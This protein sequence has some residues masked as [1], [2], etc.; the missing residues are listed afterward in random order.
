MNAT[1]QYHI[2][3]GSDDIINEKPT[4]ALLSGDPER[5]RH[6]AQDMPGVIYKKCLSENRGLN[7]YLAQTESGINF[8]SATTGM[9]GP[10]TSIVM[11]E[12]YQL[13][14]H[15][16]IRIGTSG[17]IH[18]RVLPGNIVITKAS[19]C[20]QG[21]ANDI[22]PIEYPA[23]ANPFLTVVLAEAA[24]ELEVNWFC[25][26]TA[27]VDTFFEGQERIDTSANKF[28][29]RQLQGIT[30]EYQQL[31]ILNYEMESGTLFKMANVYGFAAGC[32]CAV[33]ANRLIRE[34][35]LIEVKQ[36]AID[37]AVRV[38]LRAM[39]LFEEKYQDSY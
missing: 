13:G 32:I 1:F 11:N 23:A 6:I 4:F 15:K 31:N 9:G 37:D 17:S 14:I 22:A 7:S 12:L 36:K 38:A 35:P 33:V 34:Q 21:A 30:E 28:L 8:I 19:L 39:Q 16:V 26:L 20:R 25:G 18:P 2:G 24:R 10:S 29:L 5:A 27:S 3:F